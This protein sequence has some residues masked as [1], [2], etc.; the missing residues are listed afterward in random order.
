MIVPFIVLDEIQSLC[1]AGLNSHHSSPLHLGSTFSAPTLDKIAAAAA[2][3]YSRY[4]HCELLV[5]D[6]HCDI[7]LYATGIHKLISSIQS[8]LA[9]S[10]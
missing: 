9:I 5:T 3:H 6:I 10:I 7:R 2:L 8:W 4:F 1:V